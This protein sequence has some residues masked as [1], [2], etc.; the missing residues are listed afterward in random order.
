MRATRSWGTACYVGERGNV[1]LDVSPYGPVPCDFLAWE[2]MSWE[3]ATF[4]RGT[5]GEAGLAIDEPALLGGQVLPVFLL[6]TGPN[7]ETR[8]V[9][10]TNA[11]AG[12]HLH[13]RWG[14]PDGHRGGGELVVR[15]NDVEVARVPVDERPTTRLV[16]RSIE[17]PGLGE[18]ARLELTIESG[19]P[20][21]V[22]VDAD[23]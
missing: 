21:I 20:S 1:T 23:W 4:D 19:T 18:E 16:D 7:A 12:E 9:L 6:P 2:H 15:V 3:C 11:R 8:H 22:V 14:T 10:W 5:H 17:T 13:L